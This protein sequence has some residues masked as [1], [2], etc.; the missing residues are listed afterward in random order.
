[1][2]IV[3]W[4]PS[5][6][7]DSLQ[8]EFNRLFDTFLGNGGR[9]ELRPRRWVPAMDLVETD[10]HLV[11][12]ADLPGMSKEDVDIE[13]K[14]NVLTVS[15]ERKAEHEDK[16]DGYYRIERAFGS[17]SR[18]LT[19]PQGIDSGAIEELAHGAAVIPVGPGAGSLQ[20]R[21]GHALRELVVAEQAVDRGAQ[22][23][24]VAGRDEERRFAVERVASERLDGR[25]D[26][27]RPR[28]GR[29]H[30]AYLAG[31]PR[32]VYER[33]HV[34][35]RRPDEAVVLVPWHLAE[36]PRAARAT[37]LSDPAELP[38]AAPHGELP[39]G[40]RSRREQRLPVARRAPRAEHPV[41]LSGGHHTA[42]PAPGPRHVLEAIGGDAVEPRVAPA[43]GGGE[44]LAAD[45]RPAASRAPDGAPPQSPREPA[46]AAAR[47]RRHDEL[48]HDDPPPPNP[49]A[50]EDRGQ[51]AALASDQRQRPDSAGECPDRHAAEP[52]H[53]RRRARE[54]RGQALGDQPIGVDEPAVQHP[55]VPAR[56]DRRVVIRAPGRHPGRI[57]SR[58]VAGSL[59]EPPGARTMDEAACRTA[60]A[61][62]V[63]ARGAA[64]GWDRRGARRAQGRF[65]P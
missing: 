22:G 25:R 12:K 42:L 61:R 53:P 34:D 6:E 31:A 8:S 4:E 40:A 44:H 23:G 17:F 38:R 21:G 36:D 29:R 10:D 48:E 65:Q 54:R 14:D 58:E 9:N 5:R 28:L 43:L 15:G 2:A 46:P 63:R 49:G 32:S 64:Q 7:L 19:L 33:D 18:S 20:G 45:E 37:A 52:P 39:L 60:A 3:R 55:R 62:G 1:M 51:R 16:T 26:D 41:P 47:R 30:Q 11:L 13:V 24:C 56:R 35:R 27:G 57:A 59:I 50:E